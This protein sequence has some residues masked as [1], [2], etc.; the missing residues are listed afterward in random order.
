M[1][2]FQVYFLTS[3]SYN[4]LFQLIRKTH[5]NIEHNLNIELNLHNI[6]K[7]LI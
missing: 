7:N 4:I 2:K 1:K 5:T 3:T 6:L